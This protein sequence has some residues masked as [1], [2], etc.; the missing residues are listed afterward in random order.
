M[1]RR[2]LS[3]IDVIFTASLLAVVFMVLLSL[4][5]TAML[6]VRQTEHRLTAGALATAVLDECRSGPFELLATDQVVDLSTP[7]ALGDILRR[8]PRKG[9][10]AVEYLPVLRV[11]ASPHS[12]VPRNALA[13]LTVEVRWRER[14]EDLR[15]SRELQVAKLNR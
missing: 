14:G 11:A 10:D 13:F 15:L 4:L 6:S 9:S 3:L 12:T 1:R 8:A 2:G 5:P 7:G